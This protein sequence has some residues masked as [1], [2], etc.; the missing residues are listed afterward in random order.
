VWQLK[1]I[2]HKK[3]PDLTRVD[4]SN[5]LLGQSPIT[6]TSLLF[7]LIAMPHKA[8]RGGPG[9]HASSRGTIGCQTPAKEHASPS[10]SNMLVPT[11][12]AYVLEPFSKGASMMHS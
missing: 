4:L 6:V 2:R 12:A 3:N 5:L 7:L 11:S 10:A 9:R 1:K 8:T